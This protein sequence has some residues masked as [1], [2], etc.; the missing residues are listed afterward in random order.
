[1]CEARSATPGSAETGNNTIYAQAETTPIHIATTTHTS[2]KYHTQHH[3]IKNEN[4]YTQPKQHQ[5]QKKYRSQ[6]KWTTHTIKT[7]HSKQ[8][9]KQQSKTLAGAILQW[10][11]HSPCTYLGPICS[12]GPHMVPQAYWE[13]S[14]GTGI[15]P[16]YSMTSIQRKKLRSKNTYRTTH[17]NKSIYII[18][19]EQTQTTQIGQKLRQY[20]QKETCSH[21]ILSLLK[22]LF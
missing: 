7:L 19:T 17:S 20:A 13:W 16:E 14:L 15:S 9:T 5:T 22:S 11:R 12:L 2:H 3:I 10:G 21:N 18:H 4:T 6:Q 8:S 1:M